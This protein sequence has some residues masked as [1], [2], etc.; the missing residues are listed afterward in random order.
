MKTRRLTASSRAFAAAVDRLK[1]LVPETALLKQA[2]AAVSGNCAKARPAR[3][4]SKTNT[5]DR[6]LVNSA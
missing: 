3:Y 4:A 5:G 6:Q 1:V 2:Q